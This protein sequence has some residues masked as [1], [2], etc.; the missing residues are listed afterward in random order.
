MKILEVVGRFYPHVGGV[1]RTVQSLGIELQRRGHEVTV[2]CG[3]DLAGPPVVDGMRVIRL[4]TLGKIGNTALPIGIYRALDALSPDLVHTHVP[5]A[6]YSDSAIRNAARRKIPSVL[7]FHNELRASGIR[8]ILGRI[9]QRLVLPGTLSAAGR[10]VITSARMAD[11]YPSLSLERSRLLEIPWGVDPELLR[12]INRQPNSDFTIGFVSVLDAAHDY[13]GLDLLLES[14]RG[15]R[16]AGQAIRLRIAGTGSA[17]D[18]WKEATASMGL[19]AAVEW[20]GYVPEDEL[21][22]FYSSL[23]L[24]ALP[25]TDGF[26]EGFGLVAL[27]SLACG[28]PV[29]ISRVI[30]IAPRVVTER[31]GFVV[32]PGDQPALESALRQAVDSWKQGPAMGQRG[33]ALIEREYSWRSIGRR[34]ESLFEELLSAP[35]VSLTPS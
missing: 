33:R 1:E 14:I 26:R 12:P 8:G 17:L 25:S 24:F 5:T 29:L 22:A 35:R 6:W 16:A 9:H 20:L 10:V 15:L 18:R 4:R 2:V 11:D 19:A 13:K 31:C 21:A 27:E 32:P 3:G 34:Y 28:V 23:D 30:A 7:T